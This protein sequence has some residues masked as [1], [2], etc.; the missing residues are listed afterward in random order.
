MIDGLGRPQHVLL[1]GGTSEIGLATCEKLIDEHRL[2]SLTLAGRSVSSLENVADKLRLQHPGISITTLQI[3]LEDAASAV[4]AV[5]G[6][7]KQID[8]DLVVLSAGVLPDP[9]IAHSEAPA[10]VSAAMVNFVG[11][12]AIGTVAL[13]EFDQRGSGLLVVISSVAGE[14]IRSDNYVYG[15]TKSAL[16]AWAFGAAEARHGSPVRI[17]IVRPGM[18]RTR[19]SAG[20]PEIPLTSDARDVAEVVTRKLGSRR[21]VVWSPR[22][23]RYLML[24][25]RALPGPIFRRLSAKRG[26]LDR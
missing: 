21:T 14:R 13:H 2:V 7:W 5:S 12:M 19:M 23:L 8:F 22:P 10:A 16:D 9:R 11:Q 26:Y 4:R 24:A 17:L 15:S 6:A 1:V 25:L 20:M 18:V 3:D